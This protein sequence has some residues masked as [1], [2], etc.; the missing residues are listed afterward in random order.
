MLK[1]S[2][3]SVSTKINVYIVRKPTKT[4]IIE[5]EKEEAYWRKQA[6]EEQ[7]AGSYHELPD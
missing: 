7:H 1:N 5:H 3:Y 6:A 4:E 2:G